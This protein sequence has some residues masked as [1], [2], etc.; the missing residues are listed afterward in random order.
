MRDAAPDSDSTLSATASTPRETLG[1][2]DAVSLIVGVVIGA[3]IYETAPLV[4]ANVP[5]AA[6]ALGLWFAA[7]VLS[8]AGAACYAELASAYPR[9]GGDYFYLSRAFGPFVGFLFGWSQ[10]TVILT[11]SIGMMAYVFADYAAGLGAGNPA[12]LA[13]L[14]VV[15]LTL[16][17]V[18][19]VK[20][21]RRTQN[22][23]T[24]VKVAGL[25]AVVVAGF[26]SGGE[27]ASVPA[28]A[29][30]MREPGAAA[31]AGS[32]GLA[33]ILVLYTF[34]GWNDAA[35]VAAEVRDKRKNVARALLVGTALVTL[36]YLLVNAAFLVG[37]GFEQAR[38]SRAIAADLL[39]RTFGAPGRVA[40]SLL[41]MISALGAV[42][43][44]IFTGARVVASLGDDYRGLSALGRRNPRHDSPAGALLLQGAIAVALIV[45][46]GT[47]TGRALAVA[48]FGG[49][50]LS[51][52]SFTGHGGFDT[53]LRSTAPVFWAFF[54]L[55]G[56]SLFVLR[57]RDPRIERPFRVP[58]FPLVPLLF[59]GTCAFML[60]SSLDY[61]GPLVLV[62]LPFLLFGIP[63]YFTRRQRRVQSPERRLAPRAQ[64]AVRTQP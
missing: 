41:V 61:A 28:S 16:L 39:G 56:I 4:L 53:L 6:T 40:I 7:G 60:Q 11:G 5:N 59:A 12:L 10:L 9:S 15:A 1:F 45:L 17:N 32:L 24:L 13:S 58:L 44:L 29:E 54:L 35:F 14:A 30:L 22:A 38:Q 64:P 20:S 18:A 43:A 47:G 33:M 52:A 57:F 26:A 63:F 46:L 48:L 37:L 62:T 23:L 36:A 3:G 25:C 51:P 49:F 42:N 19:S 8:L 55:T 34:G 21:G 2:W 27:R 31:Q 50:G